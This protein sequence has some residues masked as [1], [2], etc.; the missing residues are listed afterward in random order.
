MADRHSRT[1]KLGRKRNV[2]PVVAAW[3]M[4]G[5]AGDSC[6][7]KALSEAVKKLLVSQLD[8]TNHGIK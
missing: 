8:K 1:A 2:I 6:I 7:I 5:L 4:T 3:A